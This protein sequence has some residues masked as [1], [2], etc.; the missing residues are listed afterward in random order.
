MKKNYTQ[1]FDW[2][3]ILILFILIFPTT[4]KSAPPNE[5]IVPLCR[6]FN[7]DLFDLNAQPYLSPTVQVVNATSNAGFFHSAYVPRKVDKPYFR[8]SG[9]FMIGFVRDDMKTFNPQIPTK[10]FN[11]DEFNK[12]INWSN[13]TIDT[14][15]MINYIFQNIIHEGIRTNQLQLPVNAP[16]ALGDTALVYFY[17]PREAMQEL[18]KTHPI[19]PL[20]VLIFP[21]IAKEIEN[22][23]G[24]F[25]HRLAM[26]S[27]GNIDRIV[28]GVPQLEI[29]SLYGTELL[30]RLIPP[31]DLGE[32]VGKF[33]FWGLGLKHS[34]SQYFYKDENRD[35]NAPKR[36]QIAPFD[37][38]AQIVY[39]RTGLENTVGMTEAKLNANANIWNFN[40]HASKNF[41]NY[42]EL[43]SGLSFETTNIKG[44]Y[45][46]MLPMDLQHL[47][48]LATSDIDTNG[49]YGPIYHKPPEFPGD[50][51]P[52]TSTVN[53]SSNHFK[54][55]IGASKNIGPVTLFIDY[56]V[57]KFNVFSGGIQYRF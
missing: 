36:E 7:K 56:N 20:L 17:L 48:G 9:N 23:I 15:G 14:A 51:M 30:V 19:Y 11:Q 49:N 37:L 16:T 8:I 4:V 50:D 25:P 26:P 47:I 24:S 6:M 5:Y 46:Y 32:Y 1:H 27:G 2:K 38:A 10:E 54:W 42:F 13:F 28:A 31:L 43:Y 57:S 55:V 33:S 35:G 22:V 40:L 29:G 3:I 44:T 12:F 39:Q 52:Q 45:I 21:E 41:N 53:V 34:I 18:V